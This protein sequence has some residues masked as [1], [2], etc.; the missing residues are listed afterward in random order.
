MDALPHIEKEY[1]VPRSHSRSKGPSRPIYQKAYARI[2]VDEDFSSATVFKGN[3]LSEQQ[4]SWL[5][6]QLTETSSTASEFNSWLHSQT[7]QSQQE[8]KDVLFGLL[9]MVNCD[10]LGFLR[11]AT[12][13]LEDVRHSSEDEDTLQRQLNHWRS[14]LSRLQL[15][16][17]EIRRSVQS[18]TCFIEKR[19]LIRNNNI[20]LHMNETLMQVDELFKE[21]QKSYEG[22][23]ADIALLENKRGISQAESVGKLTELGFLFLPVSCVAALFSMQV[24]ELEEGVPLNSF[25]IA[26]VVTLSIAYLGRLLVRSAMIHGW[27]KEISSKI[28][29]HSKLSNSH[30]LSTRAVISWIF[31]SDFLS[32]VGAVVRRVVTYFLP[33]ILFALVILPILFVWNHKGLD[34]GYKAVLTLLVFGGAITVAVI[35]GAYWDWWARSTRIRR[36]I[37]EVRLFAERLREHSVPADSERGSEISDPIL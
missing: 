2:P 10:I 31:S 28:R 12:N 5:H 18:F 23:R 11:S 36:T 33:L 6:R 4:F 19:G 35:P 32:L 14:V 30:P 1:R 16:L 20:F 21:S 8:P 7:K 22:L 34:S 26:A 29:T 24:K 17:Q 9:W 27:I 3:I 13:L 37:F 15:E 25:I